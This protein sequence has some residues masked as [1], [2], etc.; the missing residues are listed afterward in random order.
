MPRKA[1][2]WFP[3]A[4]YHIMARGNHRQD[5]VKDES[6]LAVLLELLGRTSTKHGVV[7]HSFC[8]MTNHYHLLLE[9]AEEP[10]WTTMKCMNQYYAEYFNS[11]YRCVGHLFQD[12]YRSCLV[13][14]TS[15]F[16]Q[17]SRYIHLNPVKAGIVSCPQLYRWSSYGSYIG[18]RHYDFVATGRVL[19]H[20][21]EPTVLRYRDFV[22]GDSL[23][24]D[25]YAKDICR[26]L[27]EEEEW[28][29][30]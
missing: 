28:L 23:R 24:N 17:T 13:K 22:E 7:V 21:Q 6:D 4:M 26:Q 15:Y 16:L 29:P 25:D 2:P 10:I 8:L 27:G 1:R 18:G 9:T 5:I 3:G 30:W 14:D 20:F 19:S 11:K 12:R